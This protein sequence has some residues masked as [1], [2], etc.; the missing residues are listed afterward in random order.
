MRPAREEDLLPAEASNASSE[1]S[2]LLSEQ[3]SQHAPTGARKAAVVAALSVCLVAG[4]F[5]GSRAGLLNLPTPWAQPRQQ[6][7]RSLSAREFFASPAAVDAATDSALRSG[8]HLGRLKES[9]R[10][11]VRAEFESG[12]NVLL[13]RLAET[14]PDAAARLDGIKLTEGQQRVVLTKLRNMADPRVQAVGAEVQRAVKAGLA[15]GEGKEELKERIRTLL[16]PRAAEL[17]ALHNELWPKD[18]QAIAGHEHGWDV[19]LSPRRLEVMRRF[20]ESQDADKEASA[21]RRLYG[22]ATSGYQHPSYG[23]PAPA[24]QPYA[25]GSPAPATANWQQQTAYQQ[26]P[27]QQTQ[28]GYGQ[29]P[30]GQNPY[31]QQG[32]SPYTTPPPSLLEEG[33]KAVTMFEGMTNSATMML[34][35]TDNSMGLSNEQLNMLGSTKYFAILAKCYLQAAEESGLLNTLQSHTAPAAPTAQGFTRAAP[36]SA[37]SSMDPMAAMSAMSEAM[38]CPEELGAE[39]MD[40]VGQVMSDFGVDLSPMLPYTKNKDDDGTPGSKETFASEFKN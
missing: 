21:Q 29:N 26:H 13:D 17:R 39:G 23:A 32:Y 27:Q 12:V 22:T 15:A 19:L 2:D 8:M 25:W 38:T 33:L 37:T 11:A 31:G 6:V 10:P 7:E 36:A 40:T 28:Y 18:L 34:K 30:Y 20:G 5:A 9:D 4:A 1:D 35:L 14:A 16:R 3:A 24:P